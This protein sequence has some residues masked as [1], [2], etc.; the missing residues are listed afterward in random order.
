M[1][2]FRPNLYFHGVTEQ[3][4]RVLR[5]LNESPDSTAAGLANR[6]VILAPSMTRIIKTLTEKG[7]ITA[8]KGATDQREL[9]VKLTSRGSRL[10]RTIG[11]ISESQYDKIRQRMRPERLALLYELLGEFIEL[12]PDA[13]PSADLDERSNRIS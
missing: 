7:W 4:W 1:R 5:A 12:D 13:E 11:P 2:Y 9:R 10:I 3:Q 8:K 6:C